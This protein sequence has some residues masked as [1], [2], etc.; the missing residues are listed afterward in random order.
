M[1]TNDVAKNKIIR[2]AI[3][4]AL[5]VKNE[6]G[7]VI[8]FRTAEAERI[9]YAHPLSVVGVI[10]CPYEFYKK[11]ITDSGL[12]EKT[13]CHILVDKTEGTI[14]LVIDEKNGD[15]GTKVIG[16]I[17]SNP[18]LDA[19]NI[20]DD[21]TF[22]A[23]ELGKMLKKNKMWFTNKDR[24]GEIIHNLMHF[25]GEW[26]TKVTTINSEKGFTKHS[27]ERELKSKI[28]LNFDL[29]IA[30]F[31]GFPARTFPVDVM[32][33]YEGSGLLFYL[34]SLELMQ[35]AMKDSGDEIEKQ[36]KLFNNEICIFEI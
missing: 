15:D 32:V 7:N 26:S 31:K 8:E 12:H 29:T 21:T 23:N 14:L 22:S 11:R 36:I 17:E 2:D 16:S 30:P 9:K 1:E 24:C 5:G 27:L 18:F 28:D 25:E 34:E 13:K 19:L 6:N 10:S 20:N 33:T 35:I 3:F 4:G